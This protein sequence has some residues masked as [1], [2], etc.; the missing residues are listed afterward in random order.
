MLPCDYI[1]KH[2]NYCYI[3]V[4]GL[5]YAGGCRAALLKLK[6]IVSDTCTLSR[7]AIPSFK[8]S[9]I[10]FLLENHPGNSYSA[11][12]S[13]IRLAALLKEARLVFWAG[14]VVTIV[15]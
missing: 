15:S 12:Q 7:E 8:R 4:F 10:F 13:K 14:K 6:I 11:L 5:N 9:K 2:K 1:L 3:F